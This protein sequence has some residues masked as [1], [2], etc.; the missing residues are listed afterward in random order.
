MAIAVGL[1]RK[2]TTALAIS[3]ARFLHG[4]ATPMH[5]R[6]TNHPSRAQSWKISSNSSRITREL[7]SREDKLPPLVEVLVGET[8]SRHLVPSSTLNF[9]NAHVRGVKFDFA[10]RNE[11]QQIVIPR[12]YCFL[13]S[14]VN[15]TYVVRILKKLTSNYN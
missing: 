13:F 2:F 12:Q 10:L 11:H 3:E 9:R 15:I 1:N 14:N 7:N 6:D 5:S 8:R 4:H